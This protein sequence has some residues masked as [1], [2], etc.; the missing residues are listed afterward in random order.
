[1]RDVIVVGAGPA[2]STA[3]IYLAEEG[4]DVLLMDK[5]HFPRDK[6]CG[7]GVVRHVLRFDFMAPLIQDC[8]LGECRAHRSYDP[9]MKHSVE[10]RSDQVLFYNVMRR[11]F[12]F[13][14][15]ERARKCG[16]EVEEGAFVKKVRLH[17]DGILVQTRDGEFSAKAVI[18][19]AGVFDPV[20]RYVR[21]S[22]GLPDWGKDE[23]SHLI[24]E[25]FAVDESFIHDVYGQ[26]YMSIFHHGF[27]KSVYAWVF[28]KRGILN[29][30]YWP[31]PGAEVDLH[32]ELDAY[33]QHLRVEGLVPEGLESSSPSGGSLPVS[34]PMEITYTPR[35]LVVGDAAGMVSPLTGEGIY[36]AMESG[37][38]AAKTLDSALNQGRFGVRLLSRYQEIWS[39]TIGEDLRVLRFFADQ[40]A[41]RASL[42]IRTAGRDR[43]LKDLFA[44]LFIGT[45]GMTPL[46][47]RLIIRMLMKVPFNLFQDIL[48]VKFTRH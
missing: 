27:R 19:A 28:P 45:M 43:E 20:A 21:R 11:D 2:G 44:K 24:V 29:I 15:V 3:A 16:A 42:I 5:D 30:G 32:A 7:G 36:Y 22:E 17:P 41:K 12:D 25:N 4:H 48:P 13:A 47:M 23:I 8:S 37:R 35:A 34:G 14:L 9:T 38:M 40:I 33:I 39:T 1:M 46:R 31:R 6:A 18:G 10:Y 26:D